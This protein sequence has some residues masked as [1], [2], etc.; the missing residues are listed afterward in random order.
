[1][2]PMNETNPNM[3]TD[4]ESTDGTVRTTASKAPTAESGHPVAVR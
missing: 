2:L 4:P 1:M 3:M